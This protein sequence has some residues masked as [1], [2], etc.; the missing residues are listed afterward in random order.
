MGKAEPRSSQPAVWRCDK[1]GP[2]RSEVPPSNTG[3]RK[4]TAADF[5]I[6][7]P[8]TKEYCLFTIPLGA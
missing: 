4:M 7:G 6:F 2:E 5:A 8:R 3:Q 1:A